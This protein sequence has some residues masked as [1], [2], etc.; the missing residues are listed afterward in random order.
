MDHLFDISHYD[1]TTPDG[2]IQSI[3]H[4][5]EKE[6]TAQV[7]IERVSP[8]FVGFDI[9]QELVSF[10][11]KSVLAQLGIDGIGTNY[12]IDPASRS[13]RLDVKLIGINETGKAL[14]KLLTPGKIIGKIFAA[15]DRRRVRDPDYLLRMFSR[16]DK[17][18]EPLLS[19][20][21]RFGN[22][23]LILEKVDNRTVAFLPV[24]NGF[25]K[26]DEDI[27]GFINTLSIALEKGISLR[28]LLKLHQIWTPGKRSLKD[29][30]LL[31]LK[32]APLHIRTVFAKVIQEYLP[33][34]FT[35]T[36]ASILQPDTFASGDIYEFYGSSHSEITD[37]PLEFY[38]LEPYR[39][40]V[41]FSDRD[42]L[43]NCIENKQ[44][45]FNAFDTAPK[46]YSN[47]T[48]IFIV[49]GT[50]LLNLKSS[51]WVVS[52]HI[53]DNYPHLSDESLQFKLVKDF[54][55]KQPSF[56]FL[57]AIEER[58]ISS[59][60]ILL[61]R[62]FPSPVLKRILLS[63]QV[64]RKVKALYFEMPSN[65]YGIYFS[66][67]DRA[68]LQD[69]VH[70]GL[71]VYWVDRATNK[72]LKYVIKPNRESG[73]FVPI[74]KVAAYLNS[75]TFGVYGSNLRH[76]PFDREL[77]KLLKGLLKLK[78][79]MHHPLLSNQRTIS[80]VTGGGPGVMEAANKIATEL[81]ILSCANIVDFGQGDEII[82]EQ[83]VNPYIEAKMS[84]RLRRIVERQAEFYLDFPI[85]L[86][87]GIGTDFEYSLEELRRKVGC[88][89]TTPVILFG[90]KQYWKA[91]I[92]SRFQ[93]NIKSGTIKGS[94]WISNCFYCVESSEAALKVYSDFFSGKLPIGSGGPVFDKG[95][96]YVNKKL[97]YT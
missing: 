84:Y 60:G 19:L 65:A 59:E 50:Q 79:T 55:T 73:L 78:K 38:T 4:H 80:L 97:E 24:K 90:K 9:P 89:T 52:D 44:C 95:F 22:Q 51:D 57:K 41:F 5:N 33:Q 23:N 1:L 85:F 46:P 67:Q 25:V 92:T 62:Y 43:Q 3:E 28:S 96:G 74:D 75:T 61:T 16:S 45:I 93:N 42:Q 7:I 64:L 36:S 37:L 66:Q 11:I 58:A 91:K 54:I 72:I 94:E 26:Y 12:E 6:A 14:L 40:Y 70:F 2:I 68:F 13:C 17:V 31:L 30:V 8:H 71:P 18:G 21:G 32:T 82:N 39:E 34:G 87:G 88:T 35:H 69:L 48:S 29:N 63:H 53:Y 76:T 27:Y 49:K 56:P 81:D 83:S 20:G 86:M 10:N 77:K 15:D 47:E